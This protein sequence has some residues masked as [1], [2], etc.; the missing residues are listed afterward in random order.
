MLFRSLTQCCFSG[1]KQSRIPLNFQHPW[2]VNQRSHYPMGTI[3]GRKCSRRRGSQARCSGNQRLA[4]A[5]QA[6]STLGMD[7]APLTRRVMATT[8]LGVLTT[9][10]A[11]MTKTQ[12]FLPHRCAQSAGNVHQFSQDMGLAVPDIAAQQMAIMARTC[13][14]ERTMPTVSSCARVN[15]ML[16]RLAGPLSSPV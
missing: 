8:T 5:T 2:S 9:I 1:N 12:G 16:P 14:P 15:A 3:P 10:G 6:R 7:P 4:P 13:P 11:P